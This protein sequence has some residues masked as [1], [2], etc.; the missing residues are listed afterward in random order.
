MT[1]ISGHDFSY[2]KSFSVFTLILC[3]AFCFSEVDLPSTS[4]AKHLEFQGGISI[5]Q[6]Q[7]CHTSYIQYSFLL[8]WKD[9]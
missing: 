3:I 4:F 2:L 7:V 6:E 1:G 5:R 8:Y 9:V